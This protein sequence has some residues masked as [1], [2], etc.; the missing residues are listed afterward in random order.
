M[1]VFCLIMVLSLVTISPVFAQEKTIGMLAYS[2]PLNEIDVRSATLAFKNYVIADDGSFIEGTLTTGFNARVRS[3][4]W[5]MVWT[6]DKPSLLSVFNPNLIPKET[7]VIFVPP[8]TSTEIKTYSIIGEPDSATTLEAAIKKVIEIS[9]IIMLRDLEVWYYDFGYPDTDRFII[10]GFVTDI[11]DG[12]VQLD[13]SMTVTI[14]TGVKVDGAF[15]YYRP[16]TWVVPP[17]GYVWYNRY[18]YKG[19]KDVKVYLN[20]FVFPDPSTDEWGQWTAPEGALDVT[21]HIKVGERNTIRVWAGER[22]WI[23]VNVIRRQACVVLLLYTSGTPTFGDV[24]VVSGSTWAYAWT[25]QQDDTW[26][27]NGKYGSPL[28]PRFVK[29]PSLTSPSSYIL[30]N[31]PPE[32]SPSL[33]VPKLGS[34][35]GSEFWSYLPI[36]LV[37][38]IGVWWWRKR[39]I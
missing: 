17:G 21:E 13:S 22:D 11:V 26:N 37:P 6:G 14:P 38:L 27:V 18:D 34:V 12:N 3:D 24:V 5:I 9:G 30:A 20:D 28:S 23:E 15:L 32:L 16:H 33:T 8:P 4:G 36:L 10:V 7:R 29:L 2:R 39:N 1:F 25:R 19:Q 35:M 31:Y